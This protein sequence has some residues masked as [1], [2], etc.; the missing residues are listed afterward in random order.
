MWQLLKLSCLLLGLVG[1]CGCQTLGPVGRAGTALGAASGALAGAA[2]GS[3]RGGSLEGA[4]IGGAIGSLAGATVGDSIDQ[5]DYQQRVD[6]QNQRA[7]SLASAV[8]PE[9]LIQMATGGVNDEI[10]INQIRANGCAV[11][12]T[13]ND[14]IHLKQRGVS[15][16]VI[17]EYQLTSQRGVRRAALPYPHVGYPAPR[18]P[19]PIFVPPPRVDYYIDPYCP[20]RFRRR[21]FEFEVGFE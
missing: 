20:P 10:M 9:Q 21:G 5:V 3:H 7:Q 13:P 14:L 18:Y 16:R 12:P 19:A 8:T 6:Y 11:I 2:I 15:D 1:I 4:L 17:S